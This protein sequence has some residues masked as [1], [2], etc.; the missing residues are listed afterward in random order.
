MKEI[1]VLELKQKMESGEEFQLID[2]REQ[3][4]YDSANINGLLIPMGGI[5]IEEDKISRDIPVIIHCR[6]GAR[7]AAAI[8][9]L[10]TQLGFTNLFN[11]KG[12]IKAWA[13]EIDT[14]LKVD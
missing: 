10:E 14:T 8:M 4:E 1:S 3:F 7:S 12:G 5:L 11:L 6:S 9:Q 2:V 13:A